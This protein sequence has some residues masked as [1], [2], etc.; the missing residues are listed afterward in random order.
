MLIFLSVKNLFASEQLAFNVKNLYPVCIHELKKIEPDLPLSY[1]ASTKEAPKQQEMSTPCADVL[2]EESLSSG[3]IAIKSF[4]LESFAK[5]EQE[6]FA[7]TFIEKGNEDYK[8]RLKKLDDQLTGCQNKTENLHILAA[9]SAENIYDGIVPEGYELIDPQRDIFTWDDSDVKV[10]VIRPKKP[11]TLN[12]PP[13]ISFAGTKSVTSAMSDLSFGADQFNNAQVHILKWINALKGEGYDELIITGH[14]LGGGLAQVVGASLPIDLAE[15]FKIHVVTFNGFGGED[16]LRA[17]EIVHGP[18]EKDR[19]LKTF[20]PT[21]DA[22]SYRLQNDLV[23]IMGKRFGESRTIESPHS[24]YQVINNHRMLTMNK[25]IADNPHTLLNSKIEATDPTFRPVTAAVIGIAHAKS[26]VNSIIAKAEEITEI[27]CDEQNE[28]KNV[29]NKTEAEQYFY[30]GTEAQ[31]NKNDV[32]A[33]KMFKLGC[34]LCHKYSCVGYAVTNKIVGNKSDT[35]RIAKK[36]CDLGDGL[37]C[38]EAAS[39]IQKEQVGSKKMDNKYITLGCAY[40]EKSFCAL[41]SNPEFV[42]QQNILKDD[43]CEDVQTTSNCELLFLSGKNSTISFLKKQKIISSILSKNG[44]NLED[45]NSE[46]LTPL[47]SAA[48]SGNL[49]MVKFLIDMGADLKVKDIFQ[50]TTLYFALRSGNVEL[51]NFLMTKKK[52]S[53]NSNIGG[54]RPLNISAEMGD[55][56]MVKFLVKNGANLNAKD[57]WGNTPLMDAINYNKTEVSKFLLESGAAGAKPSA[58]D[59]SARSEGP[60]QITGQDPLTNVLLRGDLS[61]VKLFFSKKD[62]LDTKDIFGNTPLLFAAYKNVDLEI[63]KFLVD[64]G[65]DINEQNKGGL[66]LIHY[67]AFHQNIEEIKYLLK[68]GA[69]PN[70]QDT[71]GN[72]PLFAAVDSGSLATVIFLVENGAKIDPAYIKIAKPEIAQYLKKL[73]PTPYE[74]TK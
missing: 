51:V 61:Q 7:K 18:T 66:S 70:M 3:L 44:V 24:F 50:H 13:I 25:V 40:G 45:K 53:L 43:L 33:M 52:A 1:F 56:E 41:T 6:I 15:K 63:I 73:L 8:K 30:L 22:V 23:S 65:G 37:S 49:E 4:Y 48:Q 28:D 27:K 36:S 39:M 2:Y 72:T 21:R 26:V 31:K 20:Q 60:I 58:E 11:N 19:D 12:L 69:D 5:V 9:K 34:N 14:S 29:K 71:S 32:E 35:L 38:I 10:Y 62:S 54:D 55:I 68:K 74:V 46:G 42:L 64:K 57:A 67:A 17:Y 59:V 47:L 16:A